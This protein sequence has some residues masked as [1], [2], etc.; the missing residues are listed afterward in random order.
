M[1]PF[2]Q[3]TAQPGSSADAKTAPLMFVPDMTRN[4]RGASPPNLV[5]VCPVVWEEEAV[6]PRP[7]KIRREMS[8]EEAI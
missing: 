6:K 1:R 8:Q 2:L 3:V 5:F 7:I 4:E